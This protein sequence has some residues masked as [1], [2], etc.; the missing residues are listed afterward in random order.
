MRPLDPRLLRRA[1]AARVLLAADVAIGLATALLVLLQATLLARV[2]A[3]SFEGASL[4]DVS[5]DLVL[6]ALVFAGRAVLAWG[7][8]VAG[9]LAATGVLSQL[10]LELVER[11]LRHEPA[12]LD[13]T[14]SGEVAAVAVQG[15]DALDAYFGRFVP[16]LVLAV[17]VPPAVIA[18]VVPIDLISAALM[19]LTLPLV[20]VFMVLIGRYT[21]RE[22]HARWRALSLL[23]T[24]FL[25]VVR[26]L[27]TLR[28][29]NRGQAQIAAIAET[30]EQYRRTT[31][32]TLRVAFLSG[33]VLEL[34][35]T[36]GIA[37][38]AVTVGVRLAD[39]GI[40]LQAALT[41]LLLAPELY[42][43]LRNLAAQYHASADGLAVAD[44]LLELTDGP[45]V[46]DS[47]GRESCRPLA[48]RRSGS[49][50]SPTRTPRA[51]PPSSQA[52]TSSCA[53][54]RRSGSSERVGV[55]RAPI[56]SLL[57]GLAE[58]THGRV[59]VDGAQLTST[60]QA[61]WRRSVAWVPQQPTLFHG[62]VADNIRLGEPTADDASVVEA[63][64]LAGADEFV[65]ALPDGYDT[66][67]GDGGRPVSAGERQR[68]ALARALL[69]DASLVVLDEPTANLDPESAAAVARAIEG[70]GDSRTVLVIA[71]RPELVAQRRPDRPAGGRQ[72]RRAVTGTVRRLV[73]LA[74]APRGRLALS[75][76][77]GAAAVT[78]GIGLMATAG[79]LI[80]R[81]AEGPAIL[82]LTGT[83]VA[84]RFFA[85]ARPLARY[86]ERLASHDL[87]FRVLARL[88]VRFYER[89]E[90]LAPAGL[91]AYRRGDLVS[92][93]VGDVDALQSLYLRGLAPPL[94]AIVAGAVAVGVATAILPVAG[95]ILVAG[96]LVAGVGVPAI[97]W[98]LASAAGRRRARA[99]G[100]LHAELVELLRGAPELVVYGREEETLH[101]V[102]ETDRELVRLARRDALAAG[103]ADGLGLLVTGA[104]VVAVLAVAVSAHAAGDLDRVLVAVLGLLALASFEA[105]APLSQAAREL[106]ATLAA[107]RRVLELTDREPAVRDP[108]LPA[109]PPSGP[110]ALS[111]DG[112]RA[113]YA[114]DEPLALDGVSLRLEPGRK[115]ALVGPS[116]SGKTTVVNLLLRFLDPEDGRVTLDGLDL[117]DYRQED[118]RRAI[119]VAGQD[120]HL[121]S[122][123][124]RENIRLARPDADESEIV[125]SPPPRTT[126]GVGRL[127]SPGPRHARRR[128]RHRAVGRTAAANH[129]RTSAP[130]R[131]ARARPRRADGASRPGDGRG[132]RRRHALC[133]R[134]PEPCVLITHRPEGL[135]RVDE[136]VTLSGGR[137]VSHRDARITRRGRRGERDVAYEWAA[138]PGAAGSRAETT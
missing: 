70:L 11:R 79:Y 86:L 95:A 82:S 14:Q 129:A 71:H 132:G 98:R 12:A 118:V 34:A 7:F 133:R 135:D 39:G 22:T 64:R 127:A 109:A 44:R 59:T 101:R 107:G 123:T 84:V 8:E 131:R 30:S 2:V 138:E 24:H 120:A 128:G 112:A 102:R 105:V 130:R 20:P 15:V 73:A 115:L 124:I 51:T 92:R 45:R 25:D 10:R 52:S 78:F 55:A 125:E 40:G 36:L 121:F 81:A 111:L 33:A 96:L 137:I 42:L 110:P 47:R 16:Q 35:A 88:R 9:R 50:G 37:L 91:E 29:F 58:P 83:I 60:G 114:P 69:R 126:L 75:V 38:V 74:P 31:M 68:I 6:L 53:P 108:A 122:T 89:I 61:A 106:S 65:R 56:A 80:S 21:E 116:G 77:L 103:V 3:R 63:A 4:D 46:A 85:L 62:S 32:R 19:L 28:A 54:A 26:G 67:V 72:G 94:V 117:R 57:L 23:S 1:R 17:A 13:G 18:W 104:T 134:R 100:E 41:V 27:P 113:R 136:V 48:E 66:V 87:A 99:Q 93:M 76:L 90:P 49:R 43:P 5:T 97:A 119:A